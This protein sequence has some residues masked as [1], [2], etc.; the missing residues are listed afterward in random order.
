MMIAR[1]SSLPLAFR[2]AGSLRTD[3]GVL[4]DQFNEAAETGTDVHRLLASNPE[5]DAPEVMVDELS[6]DARILYFTGAKLWREK[7]SAFMPNARTEVPYSDPEGTG[8]VDVQSISSDGKT[9]VALDWKSG[10]K[11]YSAK[12][13]LF[14][15]ARRLFNAHRALEIVTV[16]AC[17]LRTQELE[18]YTVSRARSDE[19][20]RELDASVYHWDGV[21][22][23]GDH[24]TGCRRFATCPALAA[25]NS[26][27]LAL[28]QSQTVDLANM[29]GPQLA[30][31]MRNLK[32]LM[33]MV[34]ALDAGIKAEVRARGA[35]D[36]GE[37]RILHYKQVNGPRKVDTLKAW[38]VLSSLLNDEELASVLT[39]SL[40]D[41]EELVADKAAAAPGAKRGAKKSAKEALAAALEKAGAVTQ[42]TVERFTDER[43]ND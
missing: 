32:P 15:Y 13:Q 38:D 10:R 21:Y 8:H 24:C 6:D 19:W 40:G 35:V 34:E 9:G 39:V 3:D 4:I 14:S 1:G 12:H 5:G 30:R 36:D 11:D 16:H 2:C 37:G 18:S 33:K 23:P 20:Q 42:A 28:V 22:H 41:C 17:W 27:A 7:L 25:Q 43:K 29:P 26:A 31:T